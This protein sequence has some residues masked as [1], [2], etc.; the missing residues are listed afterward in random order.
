M[1]ILLVGE[2]SR[3]HNSLKEGLLVLGNEVT[4]VGTGDKFKQYLVDFSI[5]ARICNDNKIVNFIFK[6]IRKVTRFDL[7]KIEKAIR[8]Y[9]HLPKFND[10]DHVQFVNSDA[11]ET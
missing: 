9:V 7:E 11:L 5:Y 3:L 8:F 10:V 6:S 2:Y 4:I 1:K